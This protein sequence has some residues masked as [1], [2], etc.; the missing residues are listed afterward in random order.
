MGSRP[1]PESRRV[2]VLGAYGEVGREVTRLLHPSSSVV[3]VGR[4]KT[5]LRTMAAADHVV[6]D[7]TDLAAMAALARRT[8]VV[9]NCTGRGD[10][11]LAATISSNGA[12]FVDVSADTA[13]LSR[14]SRAEAPGAPV[15]AGVGLAPGLTNL[16]AAELDPNGRID[17]A[18][19][20]GAGDRHGAAAAA[21]IWEQAGRHL[22]GTGL[23]AL[24]STRR[25]PV[26]AGRTRHRL[27]LASDFAE[28]EQL[29]ERRRDRV[30]TWVGIDPAV[31]TLMLAVAGFIPPLAPAFARLGG[32]ASRALF[33]AHDR[34]SVMV[35]DQLG[36]W[37]SASGRG[38]NLATAAV[39]ALSLERLCET[40]PGSYFSHELV[41][42]A[43]LRPGLERLGIQFAEGIG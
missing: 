40:A 16:L 28:R 7:A 9:V 38:E 43:E 13:Y 30:Y 12:A 39:T 20:L 19:V 15:L 33:R 3:A 42:L 18:L 36:G 8:D 26:A 23:R 10:E 25:L 41:S 14:L 24:R 6:A 22:S 2:A 31:G 34:W 1:A 17:I 11:G 4:N 29:A 32:W 27:L 37:R 35:T 21:W 5:S